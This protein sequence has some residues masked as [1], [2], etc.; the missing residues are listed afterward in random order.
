MLE[1]EFKPEVRQTIDKIIDKV[2]SLGLAKV[3]HRTADNKYDFGEWC[4]DHRKE[5]EGLYG[6]SGA[7]KMVFLSDDLEE[8]VIKVPFLFSPD[9]APG[10]KCYE[11]FCHAEMEVYEEAVEEGLG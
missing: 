11:D 2:V 1:V 6:D 7:T 8:W 5:L 4:R 9:I 10:S 3:V